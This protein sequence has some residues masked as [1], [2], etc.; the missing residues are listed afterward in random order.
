MCKNKLIQSSGMN[1]FFFKFQGQKTNFIQSLGM[2]NIRVNCTFSF[3]C[4]CKF[5]KLSNVSLDKYF[6][7]LLLRFLSK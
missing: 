1:F 6:I 2:K 7:Y 5:L 4:N 3:W